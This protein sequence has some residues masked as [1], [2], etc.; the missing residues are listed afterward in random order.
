LRPAAIERGLD[1]LIKL[2]YPEKLLQALPPESLERTFPLANPLTKI[3]ELKPETII[4]LGQNL[5]RKPLSTWAAAPLWICS[6]AQNF[7]RS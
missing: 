4:D 2:G 1:L 7:C 6:A 3:T 5:N